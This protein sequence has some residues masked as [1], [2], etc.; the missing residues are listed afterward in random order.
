MNTS[1]TNNSSELTPEEYNRLTTSRIIDINKPEPE[2]VCLDCRTGLP[3]SKRIHF[4]EEKLKEE[5]ESTRLMNLNRLEPE[6]K[7]INSEDSIDRFSCIKLLDITQKV[8]NL[9]EHGRSDLD[10]DDEVRYISDDMNHIKNLIT[11]N[12]LECE[13]PSDKEYYMILEEKLVNIQ[14]SF[15]RVGE[16]KYDPL[17]TCNSTHINDISKLNELKRIESDN[18]LFEIDNQLDD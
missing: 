17:L 1:A 14:E 5:C 11:L 7:F 2:L 4:Y 12:R 10:Y 15:K 6:L 18:N 16:I 13:D 3:V 8:E 9:F